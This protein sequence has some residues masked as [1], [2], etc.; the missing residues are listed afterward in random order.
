MKILNKNNYNLKY[1]DDFNYVHRVFLDKYH[2]NILISNI[3]KMQKVDLDKY[4]PKDIF[5]KKNEVIYKYIEGNN[6]QYCYS[7]KPNF[8]YLKLLYDLYCNKCYFSDISRENVIYD[9][10]NIFVIDLCTTPLKSKK[11]FIFEHFLRFLRLFNE[12]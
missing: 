7:L 8:L 4:L 10:K 6:M 12:N 3:K 1:L 2:K 5:I 9:G 11:K